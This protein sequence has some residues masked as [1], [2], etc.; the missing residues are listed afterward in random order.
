MDR[1]V[2]HFGCDVVAL[3]FCCDVEGFTMRLFF[4]L[5]SWCLDWSD[6]SL[7]QRTQIHTYTHSNAEF[8]RV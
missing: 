8:L 1:N 2:R 6:R 5:C 4:V 3:E 7:H